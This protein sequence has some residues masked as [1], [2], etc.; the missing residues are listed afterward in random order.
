MSAMEE[1]ELLHKETE[2]QGTLFLY[3]IKSVLP[4]PVVEG[5]LEV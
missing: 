2:S 5:V 3:V 1:M 4:I